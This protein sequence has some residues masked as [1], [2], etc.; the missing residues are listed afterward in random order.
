LDT[1]PPHKLIE[2]A[3][4]RQKEIDE[5]EVRKQQQIKQRLNELNSQRIKEALNKN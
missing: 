1:I 2:F 3:I 5:E 4:L